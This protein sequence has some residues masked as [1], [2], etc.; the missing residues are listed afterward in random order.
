MDYSIF[1]WFVILVVAA[2]WIGVAMIV[3]RHLKKGRAA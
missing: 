2:F 1:E 3:V